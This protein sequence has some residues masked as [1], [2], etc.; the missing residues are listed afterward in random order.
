MKRTSSWIIFKM[1][2]LKAE[3][4]PW[5]PITKSDNHDSSAPD[6]CQPR[7]P[8]IRFSQGKHFYNSIHLT[9]GLDT[10]QSLGHRH[11]F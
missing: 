3:R 1:N 9:S 7:N 4:L 10:T 5:L 6:L 2:M 8:D 11:F